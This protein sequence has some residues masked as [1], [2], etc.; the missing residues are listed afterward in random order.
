MSTQ[1]FSNKLIAVFFFFI[2][3]IAEAQQIEWIKM[4]GDTGQ[5]LPASFDFLES[6]K[7]AVLGWRSSTDPYQTKYTQLD[8]STGLEL[9]T[10]NNKEQLML[11]DE[12]RDENGDI[13]MWS[14][15]QVLK[16]DGITRKTIWASE[17]RVT[18]FSVSRGGQ[19]LVMLSPQTNTEIT[20][21]VLSFESGEIVKQ[22]TFHSNNIISESSM[23]G[24][25]DGLPIINYKFI[26]GRQGTFKDSV[27]AK[28]LRAYTHASGLLCF[29]SDLELAWCLPIRSAWITIY[30]YFD[31]YGN[32]YFIGNYCAY[33]TVGLGKSAHYCT[34][35]SV[36]IICKID[37]TSG[38]LYWVKEFPYPIDYQSTFHTNKRGQIELC[39]GVYQTTSGTPTANEINGIAIV[40][41]NTFGCE[42]PKLFKLDNSVNLWYG[43]RKFDKD[44]ALYVSFAISYPVEIDHKVISPIGRTTICIVKYAAI[45]DV[46]L[47]DCGEESFLLRPNPATDDIAIDLNRDLELETQI[48]VYDGSG[49]I[50]L[51]KQNDRNKNIDISML[52]S[53][54]YII[55]LREANG[56]VRRKKF[57]KN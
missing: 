12:Y 34:A 40:F 44:D 32:I 28:D 50:K 27:F 15:N 55:E 43:F 54:I 7:G 29:N 51:Q 31:A 30:P 19:L 53:G 9:S 8:L 6:S 4:Y 48:T 13:Y 47:Q 1:K 49:R 35:S 42:A 21:G 25:R 36:N 23:Y 33:G 22:N 41:L 11:E 56:E 57:I 38:K 26:P 16:L 14:S 52:S 39:G 20:I 2:V 46:E 18:G 17:R 10:S 45:T 37:N 3:F 5:C 24:G